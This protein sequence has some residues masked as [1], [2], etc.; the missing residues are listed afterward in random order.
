MKV[1]KKWKV[2]HQQQTSI[3]ENQEEAY[4]HPNIEGIYHGKK[5]P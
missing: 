4:V 1:K 3:S 5:I 2:D